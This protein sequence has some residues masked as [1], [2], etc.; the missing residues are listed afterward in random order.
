M[1]IKF[2]VATMFNR[3]IPVQDGED[4]KSKEVFFVQLKPEDM[5]AGDML[6]AFT[7]AEVEWHP[8]TH[9]R[10]NDN[11][12]V[13]TIVRAET[14]IAQ[15]IVTHGGETVTFTQDAVVEITI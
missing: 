3:A 4:L 8:E 14:I 13:R 7:E 12:P 10:N 15:L 5:P 6:L 1:K 9:Y 2:K 11:V